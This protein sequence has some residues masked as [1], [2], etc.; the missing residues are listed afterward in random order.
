METKKTIKEDVI[1]IINNAPVDTVH[2]ERG[3]YD[4]L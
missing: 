1:R 4:V 2:Q 3:G